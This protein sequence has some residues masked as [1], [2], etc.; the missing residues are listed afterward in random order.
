MGL[1]S[2]N[3]GF[4]QIS[5][6][7]PAVCCFT[8]NGSWTLPGSALCVEVIVIGGGG[9]GGGGGSSCSNSATFGPGGAGGGGGGISRCVYTSA[10]PTAACVIVGAGGAAGCA[11]SVYGT[12]GGN[13]VTG[14]AS[15]FGSL[16]IAY[17]G[18]G[19]GCGYNTAGGTVRKTSPGGV[20]GTGNLCNGGLGGGG[21]VCCNTNAGSNGCVGLT[22]AAGGGGGGGGKPNSLGSGDGAFGGC[23]TTLFGV[24]LGRGGWGR[25]NI[26]GLPPGSPY[27]GGGGGGRTIGF[28]VFTSNLCAGAG[29]TG[30]VIVKTY[31][32]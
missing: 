6:V 15:C 23:G 28:E 25:I 16:V 10:L 13:G 32:S 27:G 31:F 14:G 12:P 3:I 1:F 5:N 20:G 8:S 21:Q 24:T 11:S 17:G 22:G 18:G 26:A 30:F 7:N 4:S 9:G 2:G 29:A 19:G